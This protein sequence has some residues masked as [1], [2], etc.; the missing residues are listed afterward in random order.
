VAENPKIL[1]LKENNLYCHS[2]D[3][4]RQTEWVSTVEI[5]SYRGNKWTLSFEKYR[6]KEIV[7]SE[8]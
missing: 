3:K 5:M 4:R 2:F 8:E 1:F 6:G 7:V